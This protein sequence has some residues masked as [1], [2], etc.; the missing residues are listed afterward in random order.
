MRRNEQ[1]TDFTVECLCR[2]W[3]THQIKTEL[4]R[5][6][7]IDNKRYQMGIISEAKKKMRRT[8]GK[9]LATHLARSINFYESVIR[10]PN[11]GWREKLLA[12]ERLDT[13]LGLEG[14]AEIGNPLPELDEKMG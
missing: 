8:L 14:H 4:R 13:M 3:H 2:R 12:Q 11:A 9:K 1:A 7:G 5:R 10:S 6:Y